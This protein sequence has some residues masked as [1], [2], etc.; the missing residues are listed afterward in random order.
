MGGRRTHEGKKSEIDLSIWLDGRLDPRDRGQERRI[1]TMD[2][3]RRIGL[4]HTP[5]PVCA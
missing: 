3:D 4:N 5:L 1:E 2:G